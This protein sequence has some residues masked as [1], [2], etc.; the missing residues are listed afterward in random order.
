MDDGSS[1]RDPQRLT[2][3]AFTSKAALAAAALALP[4]PARVGAAA[5]APEA[6][7]PL[8]E[9]LALLE[10]RGAE[11]G[12]GLANHGPMAAEA[13]CA[14]GRGDRAA[15]WVSGYR[16]RLE[17]PAP[18]REAVTEA[19]WRAAVGEAPRVTDWAR[20]F[21]AQLEERPWPA[22]LDLWAARLAPG[23]VAAAFHGVIRT[24]H[25]ARAL[26]V[27]ETPRRRRELAAG[28]SYWAARHQALP[29]SDTPGP[30]RPVAEALAQV[31]RLPVEDRRRGLIADGLRALDAFPA[32]APVAG[33][34]NL[35][36]DPGRVI[37]ALCGA[38]AGV[39]LAHTPA[40][41]ITLLHGVTGASAVRLL[42][43]HLSPAT[44]AVVLRN[45]W[46]AAA[47]LYAV[48]ATS[49]PGEPPA[50]QD[51][52]L[53]RD[54]HVEEA[55]AARDEHAIKMTEACLREDAIAPR[56][57]FGRAARDACR[58]LA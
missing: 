31:P 3:R 19:T 9:A 6:W 51:K 35:G 44:T 52:P 47:A 10:G 55:L 48:S 24:A 43:P 5:A 12:F 34:A 27:R 2:R 56:A 21:Q 32:F 4:P 37:S 16:K 29:R 25:A 28:L 23:L 57:V 50:G 22:V 45:T 15:D 7:E 17:D 49:P 13:L 30:Q 54:G 14:M 41:L 11:Y 42:V 39:Y 53:D 26:S 20:F 36:G 18:P 33:L 38:M 8:D 58:R 40:G 1:S 46:H